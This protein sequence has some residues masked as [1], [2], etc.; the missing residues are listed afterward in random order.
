MVMRKTTVYFPDDLAEELKRTAE[1]T[2]ISEAALIRDGVRRVVAEKPT[3]APTFPLFDSGDPGLWS[4]FD[5]ALDGFGE[6]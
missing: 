4:D 5:K 3:P 6:T 1:H 2:G